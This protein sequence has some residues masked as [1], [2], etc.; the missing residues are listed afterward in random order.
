[1]L[2]NSI[3]IHLNHNWAFTNT[4]IW[5][6]V[7]TWHVHICQFCIA[8]H[9]RL[10]LNVVIVEVQVHQVRANHRD[11]GELI[12]GQLQVQQSGYVED[13][14][15]NSRVSQPVAVQP[16]KGQVSKVFEV[17]AEKRVP[18][19]KVYGIKQHNRSLFPLTSVKN[20]PLKCFHSSWSLELSYFWTML[21]VYCLLSDIFPWKLNIH[22][23]KSLFCYSSTIHKGIQKTVYRT[24]SWT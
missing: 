14:P 15:W 5:D 10:T 18:F 19:K 17:V 7:D 13:L 8:L 9:S 3:G 6:P 11:G 16:H 12:V 22:S 4:I 24:D 2:I 20:I 1:M 21:T 23:D